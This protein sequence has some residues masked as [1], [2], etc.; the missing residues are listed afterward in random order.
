MNEWNI[1]TRKF[2]TRKVYNFIKEEY[3]KVEWRHLLY[4]S[5]AQPRSLFVVWLACH[6]RLATKERLHRFDLLGNNQCDFC[7]QVETTDN[8]FFS[9][10]RPRIIWKEVIDWTQT[11]H[12]PDGWMRISSGLL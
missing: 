1:M 7:T 6:N 9:C 11:I 4:K 2:E 12:E 3:P 5:F 10:L 8:L